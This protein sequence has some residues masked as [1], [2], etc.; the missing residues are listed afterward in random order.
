M[1]SLNWK[2][3]LQN[4]RRLFSIKSTMHI[5]SKSV[6]R[7]IQCGDEAGSTVGI[8]GSTGSGKTTFTRFLLRFVT[9]VLVL[10]RGRKTNR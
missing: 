5:L 4:V 2:K 10:F 6:V 3:R 7:W 8:A 1:E 9:P